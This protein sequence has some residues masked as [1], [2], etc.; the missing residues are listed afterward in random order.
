[1]LTPETKLVAA[2]TALCWLPSTLRY[3]RAVLTAPVEDVR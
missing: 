3:L 1:M 2:V